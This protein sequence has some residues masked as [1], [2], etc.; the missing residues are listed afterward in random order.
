MA[1]SAYSQVESVPTDGNIHLLG[2]P[3]LGGLGKRT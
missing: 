1:G 2:K 3:Q